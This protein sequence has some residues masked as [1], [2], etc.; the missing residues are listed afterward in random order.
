MTGH[1]DRSHVPGERTIVT[2]LFIALLLLGSVFSL[3][4]ALSF[5]RGGDTFDG[6][7]FAWTV[8]DAGAGFTIAWLL[9]RLSPSVIRAS[10]MYMAFVGMTM[11]V[12]FLFDPD[13]QAIFVDVDWWVQVLVL[14]FMFFILSVSWGIFMWYLYRLKK[15]GRLKKR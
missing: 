10:W 5:F 8:I 12:P 1:S 7:D 11:L 2:W 15:Q 14:F 9:Y 6:L 3:W 13:L 4:S